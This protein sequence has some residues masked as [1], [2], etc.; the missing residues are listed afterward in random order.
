MQDSSHPHSLQPPSDPTFKKENE[1]DIEF[2]LDEVL[3][4]TWRAA[5]RAPSLTQPAPSAG[6]VPPDTDSP[7]EDTMTPLCTCIWKGGRF[8]VAMFYSA[9]A[10][11]PKNAQ[12]RSMV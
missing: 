8:E 5:Q 2:S 12:I 7:H 6:N 4:N 11:F 10:Y 1:D 3:F 9:E